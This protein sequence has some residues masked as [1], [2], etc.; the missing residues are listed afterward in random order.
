M[1]SSTF[2]KDVTGNVTFTTVTDVANILGNV[3][4]NVVNT[5]NAGRGI[6]NFGNGTN[7]SLNVSGTIG[8]LGGAN[9]VNNLNVNLNGGTLSVGGGIN[10]AN[11]AFTTDGTLNV[12]VAASALGIV[13]A[14]NPNTGTVNVTAAHTLTGQV[15]TAASPLKA[16]TVANGI[17][18]TTGANSVF[19][20]VTGGG[21][22]IAAGAQVGTMLDVGASG[23]NVATFTTGAGAATVGNVYSDA[24]TTGAGTITAKSFNTKS[25]GTGTTL[26]G[27]VTLLDGGSIGIVTA[28]AANTGTIATSGSATLGT[29]GVAGTHIAALNINGVSTNNVVTAG[30]NIYAAAVTQNGSTLRLA[31]DTTIDTGAGAYTV[32]APSAIDTNGY[33]LIINGAGALAINNPL[34]I[35]YTYTAGD[36]NIITTAIAPTFT[37]NVGDVS[38][39]FAAGSSP[40]DG[41]VLN[42][43]GTSAGAPYAAMANAANTS[44]VFI[45]DTAGR[46]FVDGMNFV[47]A[48]GQATVSAPITA[49]KFAGTSTDSNVQGTATSL[50]AGAVAGT[51]TGDAA[52]LVANLKAMTA[53]DRANATSDFATHD[54]NVA[55][56]T[57]VAQAATQAAQA[58]AGA[59]A[60]VAGA[61]M[62]TTADAQG[63]AAGDSGE[64]FGV[65]AQIIGGK[66]T[67]KQ[68]KG[69]SGFTSNMMGGTLGADTMISDNASIGMLIA[70]V[71]NRAKLKD[72]SAGDKL[73]AN[74]WMF[75]L[76]GNYYI[77]ATDFFVQGNMS[78]GQTSVDSKTNRLVQAGVTQTAR[79]KYDILGVGAELSAGY[80]FKFDGSYV[81]P[82]VGLRYNYFG[83]TS[84]TETGLTTA[85]QT[86]KTKANSVLSGLAGVRIGADIDMDGTMVKP[87]V[88]GNVSYAFNAPSSKTSFKINGAQ[89]TFS[90]TGAKAS[91]FGANFG[92]GV[93]AESEGFEY[94]VGYDANISDKYLAHQGSLKVKVKF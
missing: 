27:Q 1:Y 58:A 26:A 6:A 14:T 88:H 45:K 85:N 57:V 40:A 79:G 87:E 55:S 61:R 82:S 3:T 71:S 65:W 86:V 53:A 94:G 13:T 70:D 59:V 72:A 76:Y 32:A 83:D 93:M 37:A 28:N 46:G 25:T 20:P 29:I 11:T 38:V 24:I 52:T 30:G 84:Y 21:A 47:A 18:L 63:I 48:T 4:G 16:V 90:Y 34:A 89:N 69:N 7:G 2:N 31:Q 50:A 73:K 15:G 42:V 33:K 49:A 91:K 22:I 12:S 81:A 44:V 39:T 36:A 64:K 56:T 41:T 17:T 75:G 54:G 10:V 68:R 92:A 43:F 5:G 35:T 74:T 66:A 78:V 8:I 51:F 77:G 62:T 9:T 80:K 23:A 19:A 60:N 67:Q